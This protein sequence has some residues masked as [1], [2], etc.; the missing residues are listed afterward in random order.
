MIIEYNGCVDNVSVDSTDTAASVLIH[1]DVKGYSIQMTEWTSEYFVFTIGT[2]LEDCGEVII[3]YESVEEEE[4]FK[5]TR[6]YLEDKDLI[7]V[8]LPKPEVYI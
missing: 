3:Y 7:W 6:F 2:G 1:T 8:L 5:R 4:I